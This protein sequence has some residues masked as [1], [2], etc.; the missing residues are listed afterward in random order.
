MNYGTEHLEGLPAELA[1]FYAAHRE[2]IKNSIATY[3]PDHAS[4]GWMDRSTGVSALFANDLPALHDTLLLPTREYLAR[5]GKMLRPTLVALTLQAY[6]TDPLQHGEFLAAIEAM[7]DSSIIMDDYIDNSERRRGGPCAHVV[8]GFPLANISS[9]TLFAMAHG[10]FYN[11]HMDL[12]GD[13]LGALLDAV[14]AEWLQMAFGQIEEL[15][16]TEDNVNDVSIGQ[17]FQETIAR[18]AFLTFRGPLKYAGI[19][20]NAPEE[21]LQRL[22]KIGEYLL[23]GYHIRGDNLDLQPDSKAWGKIAGEDITI[24][25]RTMLINEVLQNASPEDRARAEEIINERTEDEEKKRIVY[26]LI[27]KYGVMAKA[28]AFAERFNILTKEEIDKLSIPPAS[29]QLFHEFADY[30]MVTRKI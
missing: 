25:R 18:C 10:V 12:P 21:D 9:C 28:E 8:H 6:G 22:A 3:Y 5:G 23:I 16:W 30:C 4:A 15:Y 17:Y 24:G 14:S 20:A 11:N 13:R 1:G 19:V 27:L 7:E 2:F 26:D 29:R